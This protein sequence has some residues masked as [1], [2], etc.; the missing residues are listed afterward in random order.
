MSVCLHSSH[1]IETNA[2]ES[3]IIIAGFAPSMFYSYYPHVGSS[4]EG[5]VLVLCVCGVCVC[6]CVFGDF[7]GD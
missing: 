5:K 7:A 1:I 6:V 4:S 2:A 3:N